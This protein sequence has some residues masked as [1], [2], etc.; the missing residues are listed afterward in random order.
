M[1][2]VG[3]SR[4]IIFS[5]G[6]RNSRGS[7]CPVAR[8]RPRTRV[9]NVNL[10]NRRCHPGSSQRLKNVPQRSK[11]IIKNKQPYSGKTPIPSSLTVGN[12]YSA[13]RFRFLCP[14]DLRFNSAIKN[15]T[16]PIIVRDSL[17]IY[18]SGDSNPISPKARA[19]NQ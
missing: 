7:V 11:R 17:T 12:S 16:A 4:R 10:R 2:S 15:P 18:L 1:A 9:P 14:S 5:G 3:R 6:N 13:S 8:Q 19:V